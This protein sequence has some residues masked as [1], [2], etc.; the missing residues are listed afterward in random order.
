MQISSINSYSNYANTFNSQTKTQNLNEN[1]TQTNALNSSI[2]NLVQDKSKAVSQVLGYGVDKEGFF[3][4][5]FNE[6]AGLPKDYKIY[7]KD[8]Q[9]FVDYHNSSALTHTDIDI[10]KTLANAYKIFSQLIQD[11]LNSDT[12]SQKQIQ[13]LP[14][15]YEFDTK[16]LNVLKIYKNSQD[17]KSAISNESSLQN[18]NTRLWHS[19]APDYKNNQFL[20]PDTNTIFNTSILKLNASVYQNDDGSVAKGGVLTAFLY[21]SSSYEVFEGTASILGKLNGVDDDFSQ[22]EIK[23][24]K[25]FLEENTINFTNDPLSLFGKKLDLLRSN[26]NIEDF[27]NEW[28][29]LK[30][31]SEKAYT[32][33]QDEKLN[34]QALNNTNNFLAQNN[35]NPQSDETNKTTFTPIQ[36]ESKNE[37]YKAIDTNEL[38]KKLLEESFDEKDFLE[39]IFGIKDENV[40]L[41]SLD[42]NSSEFLNSNDLVSMLSK[43]SLNTFNVLNKS[44]DVKV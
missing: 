27:K 22:E 26:L 1:S 29:K 31:E 37:T 9:K 19:F 36:A 28:L 2:S 34:S 38:L 24:L 15:G 39:M 16:N 20:S 12:F 17:F 41:K 8:I 43:I 25:A 40:N 11:E 18:K 5:D 21:A 10:A 30:A 6:A 13:N 23:D 44:L 3:T 14:I 4:S 42:L 7:A 33:M 35:D 32:A